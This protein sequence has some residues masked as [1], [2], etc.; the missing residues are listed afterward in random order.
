MPK[1]RRPE[2]ADA[3]CGDPETAERRAKEAKGAHDA[4]E[5]P[6]DLPKGPRRDVGDVRPTVRWL[7][8]TIMSLM[9]NRN[10]DAAVH[11]TFEQAGVVQ[12]IAEYLEPS[13]PLFAAPPG[14]PGAAEMRCLDV[15][16]HPR[17]GD[18]A[19]V[20]PGA[21]GW[22]QR[23]APIGRRFAWFVVASHDLKTGIAGLIFPRFPRRFISRYCYA[24][25]VG[26]V[27]FGADMMSLPLSREAMRPV[28][29]A[30]RSCTCDVALQS[31][32]DPHCLVAR[33]YQEAC[34]ALDDQQ[35]LVPPPSGLY[36]VLYVR[37]PPPR[38]TL[39]GGQSKLTVVKRHPDATYWLDQRNDCAIAF[40]RPSAVRDRYA[41][42]FGTAAS[43]RD[44][45]SL[46]PERLTTLPLTIIDPLTM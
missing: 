42:Y 44:L 6:L 5:T 34:L 21:L 18:I 3:A 46:T 27:A 36:R 14:V 8:E 39:P 11:A 30:L 29:Q 16:R 41:A 22:F 20:R 31:R 1:R 32:H 17:Y 40:A 4:D 10:R 23:D 24:H 45:L 37:M 15:G 33:R 28:E 7:L 26:R 38:V 43:E 2:E 35:L 9:R 13:L 25:Q 19:R 12:I